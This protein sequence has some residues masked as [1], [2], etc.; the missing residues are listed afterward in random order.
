ME[1]DASAE[2]EARAARNQALF[3]VVNE[4]MLELNTAL[5]SM[6]DT[7][8]IACE[9]ADTGCTQMITIS[10]EQYAAVRREPRHFAVLRGHVLPDVEDVVGEFGEYV[11]VEKQGEAGV[12]AQQSA[13]LDEQSAT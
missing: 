8:V 2:R 11:V 4:K 12:I 7:F 5:S 9:C 6:T 3:R 10:P 1:F 13:H